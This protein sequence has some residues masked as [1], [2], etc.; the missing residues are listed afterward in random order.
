VY[1][2]N[3]TL[4]SGTYTIVVGA[5]GAERPASALNA[6]NSVNGN[7]GSSSVIQLNGV[8]LIKNTI[9]FEG[10]G[11]GGGGNY[12]V[13]AGKIRCSA[14]THSAEIH[15]LLVICFPLTL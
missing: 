12:N 15:T 10:K 14:E 8:T 7:D 9:T 5:G 3:V 13:N 2:K 11:G 6:L 1:Q 4:N